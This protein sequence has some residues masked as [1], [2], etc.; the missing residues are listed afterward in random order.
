MHEGPAGVRL[1]PDQPRH[2]RGRR[3]HRPH[4]RHLLQGVIQKVDMQYLSAANY[5]CVMII[6]PAGQMASCSTRQ[7]WTSPDQQF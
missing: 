2:P 1:P 4:P 3:Q 5:N 6:F 7:L